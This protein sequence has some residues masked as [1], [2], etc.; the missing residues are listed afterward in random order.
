MR[1]RV[2]LPLE[3]GHGFRAFWRTLNQQKVDRLDRSHTSLGENKIAQE[4]E[5]ADELGSLKCCFV[6]LEGVVAGVIV[7]YR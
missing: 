3:G 2:Q 4:R 5:G 6:V 7:T 1:Q